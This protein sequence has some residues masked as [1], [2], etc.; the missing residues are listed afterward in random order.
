MTE[1]P[2]L[3]P[4]CVLREQHDH[5]FRRNE[6][7]CRG[8]LVRWQHGDWVSKGQEG[9]ASSKK[10]GKGNS[11][12]KDMESWIRMERLEMANR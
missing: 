7:V 1:V 2:L 3:I 11:P 5:L 12:R 6:D 9:C 4:L 10:S 8:G